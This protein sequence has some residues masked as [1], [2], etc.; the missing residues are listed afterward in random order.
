MPADIAESQ[1]LLEVIDLYTHFD[2]PRGVAHAVD[3]ISFTLDRGRTLGV[4]GESGSGK[5]VLSRTIIDILSHDGSVL[6]RGKVMFEGRDLRELSQKEMREV[7]GR[8]I[9]MVF[10]DPM[11]SL[12]PVKRIGKQITEVLVKRMGM[13]KASANLRAAELIDSVGIPDPEQQLKR[14][15]MHLSGGM[16]Q[17]VAI[18]I[19]LAGEPKLLIADEPTTALDVT[20]QAQILDLLRKQQRER[21]MAVILITH[22][23]GIV[24]GYT[25][26]VAVMYAGKIVERCETQEL[27]NRPRM[28][29]TEALMKSAPLLS[30]PPHTRLDAIP[31]LPPNLLN[32]PDGCR[33]HERCR[34]AT[35]RCLTELPDLTADGSSEHLYACWNPLEVKAEALS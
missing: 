26:D 10:Q 9:A 29:Y 24:S 7:R 14:Y 15:P 34:Y 33:F 1:P 2:T 19:A 5:S 21:N 22:N 31:G 16:R 13:N 17:R 28:P 6:Y 20:I 4:V 23:L 18:A 32:V 8:E 12:N 3:G 35:D 30:D 11:S 27:M 25:D